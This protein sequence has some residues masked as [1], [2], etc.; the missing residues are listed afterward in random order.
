M[1]IL[2]IRHAWPEK[3]GFQLIRP[4]GRKD[5]TFLHFH[6]SVL[7]RPEGGE[8]VETAP[9][10]CLFYAPD[11]PQWFCSRT[12][13]VHD[14]LHADAAL[15]SRLQRLGIPENRL[16][17]PADGTQ[18]TGLFR[19]METEFFAHRPYREAL[20]SCKLNEFL[21]AAARGFS[22]DLAPTGGGEHR[23]A[24]A[25]LCRDM[26][27]HPEQPLRVESMAA[28]VG[29]STPRFHALYRQ[30]FGITPVKDRIYARIHAAQNRL[31]TE[32]IPI[33]KLAEA[34][35]YTNEYHFIRQFRQLVGVP[36]NDYRRRRGRL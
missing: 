15:G 3:A 13:L 4:V 16:F 11:T 24:L 18:I 9:D 22:G 5:Y 33:W 36:P 14:W 26:L 17:Y 23:Q 6:G 1:D 21:I 29:L 7:V 35:G 32:D 31:L 19:E 12:P 2:S 34:L 20:L 8:T 27:L 10:A 25:A 30:Y 28:A